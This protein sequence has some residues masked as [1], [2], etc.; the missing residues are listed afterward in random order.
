MKEELDDSLGL[1]QIDDLYDPAK[2]GNFKVHLQLSGNDLYVVLVLNEYMSCYNANPRFQN[3][4]MRAQ[5]SSWM[6][7]VAQGLM[8]FFGNSGKLNNNE[9]ENSL[10]PISDKKVSVSC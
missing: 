1:S 9:L 4:R 10:H 7:Y 6:D 8:V 2:K 3:D 5:I